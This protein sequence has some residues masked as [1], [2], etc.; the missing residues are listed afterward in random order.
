MKKILFLTVLL[1]FA[2]PQVYA[3]EF[4]PTLL[5][6]SAPKTI[7]YEFD[8]SGL[9]IPLQITG[10]PASTLFLVYTRDKGS[11]IIKV[12]NGYLGWHYVNG[13]DTCMYVSSEYQLDIGKNI[14]KW[15]G[16]DSDGKAIPQG[17]YTYYIWG[18][19]NVSDRI[20][21]S[22]VIDFYAWTRTTLISHDE[23]GKALN[24]PEI[25]RETIKGIYKGDEQRL[26][27][28]AKWSVGGDP[29]DASLVETCST[30]Q[31]SNPGCLAFHPDDYSYFFKTTLNI[32]NTKIIRKWKWVPNGEAELQVDWG[33]EGE[34]S[35]SGPWGPGEDIGP[36][37]ITDGT[38]LFTDY[39]VYPGYGS[40]AELIY[41][42]IE[43]GTEVQRY[44]WSEWCIS[45]EDGEAG[46][47]ANNGPT[48]LE[49][50]QGRIIT[51]NHGTCLNFAMNPYYEDEDEAILWV[52]QNGDHTGDHNFEEDSARP[53]VCNDYNVGPYK[54]SI[55]QDDNLFSV[56]TAFDMG[57][58][59]FGLFAPD[60]TGLGYHAYSG[61]TADQKF[62]IQ[63][64]DYGSPY[65]GLY[66]TN[67]TSESD[68]WAWYYVG[69]D[70]INGIITSETGI[71]EN[72]P[73]AF[74]VA[75]NSPNPFN[76]TTT[77]KFTI[78][79]AGNVTIG[80][81]NVAGQ[82]VDTIAN[83]FMSAGS[84]SVTWDASGFS[85]GIY[86]YTVKSSE[87]SKTMKMTLL[88]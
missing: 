47:Q 81:F 69:H 39:G 45:I 63:F 29:E 24:N 68:P 7:H 3:V 43:D 77:I 85:A 23:S 51:N 79:D 26:C 19:D 57:A 14:I 13:I 44:D 36:G 71:D 84:H 61:E 70:T 37:V 27:P 5:K 72:N 16:K 48:C 9:E 8:G 32:N 56:F 25:Y 10:T 34:Y 17:E 75:Q 31:W 86:F 35:F 65:D 4:S 15:D 38:Y 22:K 80:I 41:V 1:L 46:G 20:M 73:A 28:T 88:K 66:C 60:G 83:E 64:I 40:E 59:S 62:G 30:W 49:L 33:E 21:M 82:K 55:C 58:V 52:N 2:A 6:F 42:D 74:S 18:F 11:N 12:Q 67:N 78:P 87:F 50:R 76:P 54:Y 53:W